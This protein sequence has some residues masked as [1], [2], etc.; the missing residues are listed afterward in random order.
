MSMHPGEHVL[1][2]SSI[3]I[4]FRALAPAFSHAG[5][6][7]VFFKET[8]VVEA[9]DFHHQLHH[10]FFECNYGNVDM[11]WDRWFGSYHDGSDEATRAMRARLGNRNFS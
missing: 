9:A 10:R 6:E 8:K 5:F 3:L 11:P 4:H 7:K 1:Y 2:L